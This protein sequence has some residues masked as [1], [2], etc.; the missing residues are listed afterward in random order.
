MFD[1]RLVILGI[2]ITFIGGLGYIIDTLKG[3]TK[4]NRVTWSIWAIAPLIAFAA[5][6]QQGVGAEAWMTFIVG[7]NPLLI[8]LASFVNKNARWELGRLDIVCGIL[9]ILGLACWY[10]TQV[11][12]IAIFFSIIADFLAAIPTLIKAYQYPETES[13][14]EF[15]GVTIAAFLTMLTISTWN[16]AHVGFP[17]YSFLLCGVLFSLV[18]F[19]LGKRI[20]EFFAK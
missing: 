7:F 2:I 20:A 8:F 12:N 1:E 5:Q 17:L 9:A 18:K 11:G 6:K 13:Y 15:L 14:K 16:F 10:L 3:K 19:K 4:P